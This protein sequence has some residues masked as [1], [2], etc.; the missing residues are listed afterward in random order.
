MASYV[1]ERGYIQN[2]GFI[3]RPIPALEK[4]KLTGP[5]AIVLHRTAGDSLASALN[6]AGPSGTHFYVDKDGSVYQVASLHRKTYHV[7]LIKSKCM[8]EDTCPR[9]EQKTISSWGWAPRRIHDHEKAKPYPD[10]YP[11]NEDSVG[12]EVVSRCLR[13]CG[14]G[15]SDSAVW[16]D[17][18][19]EQ[20]DS[21]SLLVRL[22]QRIYGLSDDDVYEHDKVSYK[23]GGEGAGLY[24]STANE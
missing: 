18:T 6:A 15:D 17:P 21:I 12:I 1:D 3:L 24:G 8:A 16:E 20:R 4:G 14:P 5:R 7:G 13:E 9:T 10:R 2:A 11:M 23:K 19:A 22:L